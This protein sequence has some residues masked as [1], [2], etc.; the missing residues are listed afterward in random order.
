MK[1]D[2]LKEYT[3]NLIFLYDDFSFEK[4]F[5]RTLHLDYTTKTYRQK[6]LVKLI[7]DSVPY[8]ALTEQEM[9][10]LEDIDKSRTAWA[11]I[12]KARKDKKGDY[13]ELLLYLILL[14]YY[15]APKFVTKVRL[16]SSATMQ[17]NGYDC[18]H[19]TIEKDEPVLWLGESKF[20]QSFSTAL[21]HAIDSL[22]EHCKILYTSDEMSILKPNVEIN[23]DYMSD[24]K[25]LE[26]IFK[27]KSIDK[28][29]FKIPVLLTYDSNVIK[30]NE[31]ISDNFKKELDVE[32]LD[33]YKRVEEKTITSE[34]KNIEFIF[35]LFPFNKVAEIKSDLE[36]IETLMR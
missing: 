33:F 19:F 20:H 26:S 11:R 25:K 31:D 24:F 13:G 7:R 28:I 18:A 8:F 21:T 32:L 29:K 35:M 12:S 16:R 15:D 22:N 23:N 27:G 34:L 36:S 1:T 5:K 10:D 3:K 2:A 30:N 6:D 17:I 9:I 14:V 4:Y